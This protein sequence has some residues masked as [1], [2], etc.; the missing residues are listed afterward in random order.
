MATL[1]FEA[2]QAVIDNLEAVTF[3]S[4]RTAGNVTVSVTDATIDWV[5][6]KEAAASRGVYQLGDAKFTIPRAALAAVGGMKPADTIT[7]ATDGRVY[8]V[9]SVT[10][11]GI[12][13][14]WNAVGRDLILAADLRST[15]TLSR[16]TTVQDA[17]GRPAKTAYTTVAA[18]VP[19]RVQ[20][21]GGTVA[22]PLDLLTI[23]K[24]YTAFLAQTVDA[25]ANDK[26]VC[27]GV[28]YSVIA[29]NDPERITDLPSLTL[30]RIGP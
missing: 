25:R 19:C 1:D 11:P 15:G 17:A 2:D 9:L 5:T 10:P 20:P 21:E 28:T 4:A 12:E 8:T 3:A 7:R 16:P 22:N 26:F 14:V 30:E 29:L 27:A 23:P 6:L 24:R 13:G 18:D